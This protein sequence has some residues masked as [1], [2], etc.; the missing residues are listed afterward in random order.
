MGSH[1]RLRESNDQE[2]CSFCVSSSP[3]P[4]GHQSTHP[5]GNSCF[6][7]LLGIQVVIEEQLKSL[8]RLGRMGIEEN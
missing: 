4:L 8:D 7:G 5:L 2:G 6:V 3:F 1:D